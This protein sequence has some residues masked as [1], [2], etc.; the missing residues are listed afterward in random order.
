M[1]KIKNRISKLFYMVAVLCLTALFSAIFIISNMDKNNGVYADNYDSTKPITNGYILTDQEINYSQNNYQETPKFSADATG[2]ACYSLR[3]DY[4]IYTQDQDR[5]GLCW[6]YS[7]NMAL[8]TTLMMATGEFYDFS[9]TWAS[10]INVKESS[11]YVFGDGGNAFTFNSLVKKYGLVLESDIQYQNS[12]LISRENAEQ[13]Y[14]YYSQFANKEIMD[15]LHFFMYNLFDQNKVKNHVYNF[16]GLSVGMYW[17]SSVGNN[18]LYKDAKCYYK[19]PSAKDSNSGGHAITIIG[20][21]DNYSA[22]YN[23]KTYTGAWICL[24]SWG[25]AFGGDSVLYVFYEDSDLYGQAYGYKYQPESTGLYYSNRVKAGTGYTTYQTNL[26]GKYYSKTNYNPTTALTKQQ[27][28]Y[29]DDDVNITYSYSISDDATVDNVNIYFGQEDVTSNFD[30]NI[31]SNNYEISLSAT[32]LEAGPYKVLIDYS[33]SANSEEYL[34]TIYVLNGAELEKIIVSCSAG[35]NN[36]GYYYGYNTYNY[37]KLEYTIATTKTSGTI[38]FAAYKATYSTFEQSTFYL[39]SISYSGLSSE[40]NLVN[41]QTVIKTSDNKQKIMYVT[42]VFV[43][44]TITQ[45]S[46]NIYYS[47]DG[48]TIDAPNRLVV[49][50]ENGVALTNPIKPGYDFVGWFYDKEGTKAV[51]SNVL[52]MDNVITLTNPKLYAKSYYNSYLSGSSMAFVYAKWILKAPA[53]ASLLVDNETQNTNEE[54]TITASLN[55][56]LAKLFVLK[57]I[58]WFKDGVKLENTENG[59][60]LKQT[61][62]TQGAYNYYAEICVTLY[63]VEANVTTDALQVVVLKGIDVVPV[64]NEGSFTWESVDNAE[65]YVVTIYHQKGDNK[66]TVDTKNFDV[67]DD[68]VL[69]LYNEIEK[70][71]FGDGAYFV[72]LKAVL[73]VG[74]NQY[75]TKE[76][77]SN[78]INFYSVEFI[79]YTNNIN[80][81]LVEENKSFTLPTDLVKTG[82]SF[83]NWCDKEDRKTEYDSTSIVTQNLTLYANWKMND[84]ENIDNVTG[85]AKTYDKQASYITINPTHQSGLSNFEYVW[86]YQKDANSK[87]VLLT[88][89]TENT[90][91]VTNVAENGLYYAE[92]TLND[93]DGFSVTNNTNKITVKIDKYLTKINTTQI[94]TEYRYT[95]SEQTISSGAYAQEDDGTRISNMDMSYEIKEPNKRSGLNKFINVPTDQTFTLIVKAVGNDNYSSAFVEVPITVNKAKAGL[96]VESEFQFFRYNGKIIKPEYILN[97]TEQ[98]VEADIYPVNVN[99]DGYDVTLTAKES[100]NYEKS[101]KPVVVHVSINPANIFI[102]VNDVSSVIFLGKAKLS[103]TIIDGEVYPGDDLGIKLSSDTVDTNKL[104]V[105]NITLTST[106]ENYKIAVFEGVYR[107]TAW[108]YYAGVILLAFFAYITITLLKKR[109]Y[110]YEFETNGGGIVSPIDTKDKNAINIEKPEREGYKFAGWYTDMELT[111]PFNYKFLK[112]KGKTLYAKWIKDEKSMTLSD[113]LVSA[114]NIVDQIQQQLKPKKE[115]VVTKEDIKQDELPKE[116]KEKTEEEKLQDL[117]DSVKEKQTMSAGEIE[118]FIKKITE[119]K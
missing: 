32:N 66:Q 30:I 50:K 15:N 11:S 9:E 2:I 45:V 83:K 85:I 24:N 23:G 99:K 39:T 111:K 82:Y 58:S 20:W 25:N 34:N 88:S 43:S 87:P 59:Y 81:L 118:E 37:P 27:N 51:V 112:S 75:I 65:S 94:V 60:T 49:D 96:T 84:I 102:R 63:G 114:Q 29:F 98:I 93:S 42:V 31:N 97:N 71:T 18:G 92:I 1:E 117:I 106:N 116:P 26:K 8:G 119:N 104:G 115:E 72:G 77:L 80:N 48:G 90:I 19:Y 13:Y 38:S 40:N 101:E 68:K 110:Q 107:V 108:P 105:Y 7:S 33:N 95:G 46:T 41:Y 61:I 17:N 78:E 21:D 16:G 73:S 54:F 103:Y 47:L 74:G 69:N 6:A 44:S 89:K 57:S 28:M 64:Y 100:Q 22:T 79:T 4:V 86:Y 52:T 14:N 109:R 53:T 67:A 36:N 62:D 76:V 113:E 55:H 5:N 91:G 70:S 3:D 35:I 56:P 12:Y 10:L